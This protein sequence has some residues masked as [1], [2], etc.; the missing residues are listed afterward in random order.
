MLNYQGNLWVR[1]NYV[2][3][4]RTQYPLFLGTVAGTLLLYLYCDFVLL[5]KYCEIPNLSK[6][7]VTFQI[8]SIYSMFKVNMTEPGVQMQTIQD[9]KY[10]DGKLCEKCKAIK[11]DRCY[12]C[13]FC[14]H[15]VNDFEAHCFL[16]ATCI[17]RRNIKYLLG[18]VTFTGIALYLL[19]LILIY[20]CRSHS[21]N[22]SICIGLQE[23]A[24]LYY[25]KY[26]ES[27]F[28]IGSL[29]SV[30]IYDLEKCI[31]KLDKKRNEQNQIQW[32]TFIYLQQL[33]IILYSI[34]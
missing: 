31:I 3:G 24:N 9:D 18:L 27:G 12:H 7:I 22:Y 4:N 5:Q 26:C 15:C 13:K 14:D 20:K 17:G 2:L 32:I 28:D 30:Y 10:F 23:R 34:L 8:L 19:L 33:Q 11:I 21:N 6:V 1:K 16:M 29:E 25:S